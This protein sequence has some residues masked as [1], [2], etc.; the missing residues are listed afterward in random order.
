VD[1]WTRHH[2][3]L[4]NVQCLAVLQHRLKLIHSKQAWT[5]YVRR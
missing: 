5:Q 1:C 2:A 4:A 3:F